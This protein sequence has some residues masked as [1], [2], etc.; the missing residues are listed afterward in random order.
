MDRIG[1]F[2]CP[3]SD[4]GELSAVREG[5]PDFQQWEESLHSYARK[6]GYSE[7][8]VY[9]GL[10]RWKKIPH[11]ILEE[12]S[13]LGITLREGAPTVEKSGSLTLRMQKGASPCVMGLSI[14]GAFSRPLNLV[15]VANVLS[16]AGKVEMN[17]EE[18][19]CSIDG[20]TVFEEGALVAKGRDLKELEE[21]VE[22]VRRTVV[23]AEECVGC[24]VCIAR[25][26]EGALN[27]E[28][29][30]IH[31]SETCIHCGRCAEPCPALTFGDYA[32]EL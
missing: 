25:C 28:Q 10:W 1:C 12:A 11:S 15:R 3:A 30:K 18:G 26:S 4:L 23:K 13:R 20:V 22:K 32:F 16:I 8:W 9:Y 24:G 31:V 19:W 5:C 2:L 21:K 29:D 6:N 17:G 7:G 27:I 14:E